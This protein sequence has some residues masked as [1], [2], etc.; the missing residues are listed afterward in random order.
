MECI[1]GGEL[2]QSIPSESWR[3]QGM[4]KLIEEKKKAV[5]RANCAR[6]KRSGGVTASYIE[7]ADI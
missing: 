7:P 2:D 1:V 5:R 3:R 6:K 4:G